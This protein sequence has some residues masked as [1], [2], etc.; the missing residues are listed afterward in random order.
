M[1]QTRGSSSRPKTRTIVI[2]LI[3]GFAALVLL[4][5]GSGIDRQPPRVLLGTRLRRAVRGM[6]GVGRSS[7]DCRRRWDRALAARPPPIADR[8]AAQPSPV[9]SGCTQR[10][11]DS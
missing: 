10:M 2:A 8:Q 5:P 3:A 4:F 9:G 1:E 7:C 6:G 11:T